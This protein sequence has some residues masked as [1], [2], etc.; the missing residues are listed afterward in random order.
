MD[1]FSGI[2]TSIA[3]VVMLGWPLDSILVLTI[4]AGVWLLALGTIQ[5][6]RAFR[7][8]GITA[9]RRSYVGVVADGTPSRSRYGG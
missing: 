3:G 6:V 4:I 7:I 1:I 5:I 9:A 2:I 8:R